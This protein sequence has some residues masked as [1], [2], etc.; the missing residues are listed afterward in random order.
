MF[1]R[2]YY[3][4]VFQGPP[5]YWETMQYLCL[6]RICGQLITTSNTYKLVVQITL[7]K[8]SALEFKSTSTIS[9]IFYRSK[10]RFRH[11]VTEDVILALLYTIES[12]VYVI[13]E[14]MSHMLLA[15][16][17]ANKKANNSYSNF[18]SSFFLH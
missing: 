1:L 11:C 4:R 9:R 14:S 16:D 2:N 18:V 10:V 12:I 13:L 17:K 15:A 6:K 5:D 3:L 8:S 7:G